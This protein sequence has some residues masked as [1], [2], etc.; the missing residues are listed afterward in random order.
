MTAA[1]RRWVLRTGGTV[2]DYY[3]GLV[4]QN[5]SVAL[6]EGDLAG[7]TLDPA[8]LLTCYV[9]GTRGCTRLIARADERRRVDT[10]AADDSHRRTLDTYTVPHSRDRHGQ[11]Q[12]PHSGARA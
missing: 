9:G 6:D 8:H 2:D 4:T 12:R 5:P 3:T 10:V 7:P 11:N 1:G